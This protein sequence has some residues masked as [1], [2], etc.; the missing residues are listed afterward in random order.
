MKQKQMVKKGALVYGQ[1][2][3]SKLQS[4]YKKMLAFEKSKDN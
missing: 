2:L 1:K 4:L 3:S